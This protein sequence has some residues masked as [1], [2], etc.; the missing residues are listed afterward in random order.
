MKNAALEFKYKQAVDVRLSDDPTSYTCGY[1]YYMSM[2][3]AEK[4]TGKRDVVH[5]SVP[6]L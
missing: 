2:L 4:K 5:L 6:R 3:Q 1:Q